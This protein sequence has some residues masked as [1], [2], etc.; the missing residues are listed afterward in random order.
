MNRDIDVNEPIVLGEPP[1][2]VLT[3]TDNII[4]RLINFDSNCFRSNIGYRLKC[5]HVVHSYLIGT[6]IDCWFV[7]DKDSGKPIV[8]GLLEP[9]LKSDVEDFR[10]FVEF[11]RFHDNYK[12]KLIDKN[13]STHATH[14]ELGH[15]AGIYHS[16]DVYARQFE[17]LDYFYDFG[18]KDEPN[19]E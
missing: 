17:E 16:L 1:I 13:G 4:V 14:H 15:V 9:C 18:K 11:R 3:H 8:V 6:I 7:G 12:K 10:K 5:D 19:A 2:S